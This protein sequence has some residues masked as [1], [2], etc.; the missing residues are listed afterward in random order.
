MDGVMVRHTDG[1]HET[2][3]AAI[4]GADPALKGE[5]DELGVEKWSYVTHTGDV[6]TFG[7]LAWMESYRQ[8]VEEAEE[9]VVLL[10]DRQNRPG[11]DRLEPA[12]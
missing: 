5:D 12:T 10:A 7:R 1:Y 8:G 3:V 9:V 11:R 4:G 6:E 2:K